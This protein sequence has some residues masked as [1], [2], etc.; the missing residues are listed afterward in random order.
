[1]TAVARRG[2]RDPMRTVVSVLIAAVWVVIGHAALGLDPITLSLTA[3]AIF[4]VA[5]LVQRRLA[6]R[7]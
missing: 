3:A 1:V 7:Q 2:Y 5:E 4:C 6:R